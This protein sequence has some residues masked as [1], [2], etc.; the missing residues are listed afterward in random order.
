[1]SRFMRT[2]LLIGAN[3]QNKLLAS[4]VV[5]FGVGG[6]GGFCVEMLARSGV[7]KIDLIDYDT[8]DIT[9]INRQI[10]ALEHTIGKNKVDVMKERILQINPNCIVTTHLLKL[11]QQNLS[12]F[13][14]C[15]A[16]YV[17]DCID[18]VKAKVALI[19]FCKQFN[20][21]CIS[22]MGAANRVGIPQFEVCDI[23]KTQNDRLARRMRK[24]LKDSCI[25]NH[26]VVYSKQSLTKLQTN[27]VGSFAP[28]P[29]TCGCILAGYVINN[30]LEDL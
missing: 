15:E 9:N 14:L 19:V 25:K 26:L 6:V 7:G 12:V 2:E 11:T 21:P 5:V 24:L 16:N 20:I 1:M 8:I 27:P 17:I 23:F 30:L 22:A 18:D 28:F 4:R 13:N 10:I 3:N 29:A